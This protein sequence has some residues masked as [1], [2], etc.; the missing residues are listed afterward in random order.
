SEQKPAACNDFQSKLLATRDLDGIDV[1]FALGGDSPINND[2]ECNG[3]GL[4]GGC[5][6]CWVFS[7]GRLGVNLERQRSRHAAG[8]DNSQDVGSYL[9]VRPNL[10]LK[11]APLRRWLLLFPLLPRLLLLFLSRHRRDRL[12]FF[13]SG[14]QVLAVE[15]DC[16]GPFQVWS[17]NFSLK[18]CSSRPTQRE[19]CLGLRLL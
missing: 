14:C 4:L 19:Y 13:N 10:H 11:N 3:L 6:G 12:H 18:F 5:V 17:L 15:P 9:R 1:H 16:V 2:W 7:D 8:R